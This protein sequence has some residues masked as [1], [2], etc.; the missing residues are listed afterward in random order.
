MQ[1]LRAESERLTIRNAELTTQLTGAVGR[2]N[3]LSTSERDEAAKSHGLQA[4]LKAVQSERAQVGRAILSE[5]S[6][7]SHGLPRHPP[8]A[9]AQRNIT[10]PP[11]PPR[12][13]IRKVNFAG[14]SHL[15][16]HAPCR[17][18]VWQLAAQ[19]AQ[20]RSAEKGWL[21]E[22]KAFMKQLQGQR[23]TAVG[24]G[25]GTAAPATSTGTSGGSSGAVPLGAVR[26]PAGGSRRAGGGTRGKDV[27][28]AA[29]EELEDAL[30]TARM[31]SQMAPARS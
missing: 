6:E 25:S 28:T 2:V 15:A 8:A 26:Q 22:R 18:P 17:I 3:Q 1:E 12:V 27:K 14:S 7:L 4:Q 29:A 21:A 23:L 20:L 5:L 13:A 16:T 9:A 30:A 11:P 19:L 24:G 10:P 31:Q